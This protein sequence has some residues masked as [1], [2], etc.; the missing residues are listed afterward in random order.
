[1]PGWGLRPPG[2][3]VWAKASRDRIF[4]EL[5]ASSTWD[6][7]PIVQ[8]LALFALKHV[9]TICHC[10]IHVLSCSIS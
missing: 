2:A 9:M 1:M 4:R 5:K 8:F 6:K 3:A 10:H 7:A